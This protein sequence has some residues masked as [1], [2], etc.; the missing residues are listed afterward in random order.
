VS[1][2]GELSIVLNVNAMK[3]FPTSGF[4]LQPSLG[5][6]TSVLDGFLVGD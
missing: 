1:L 4:V 3:M 5:V 2:T 6:M